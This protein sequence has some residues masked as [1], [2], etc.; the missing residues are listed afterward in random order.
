MEESKFLECISTV[1]DDVELDDLSMNT[2]FK[3]LDEWS[4]LSAL[5]LLAVVSDE[6]GVE[7]NNNDIK[8]AETIQDLFNIIKNRV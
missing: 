8:N 7:L 2:Q 4:S 5:G 6:F 1:F 3:N